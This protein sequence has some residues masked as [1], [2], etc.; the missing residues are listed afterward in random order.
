VLENYRRHLK[1]GDR[2]ILKVP[3]VITAQKIHRADQYI[4]NEA[5]VNPKIFTEHLESLYFM[6]KKYIW[7][8]AMEGDIEIN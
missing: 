6:L 5:Y 1:E 4:G 2:V 7:K 3:Q 8:P